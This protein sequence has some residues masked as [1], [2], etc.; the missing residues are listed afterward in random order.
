[1]KILSVQLDGEMVKSLE[2]K[3]L[4]AG[5][6]P[7]GILADV[8]SRYIHYSGWQHDLLEFSIEGADSGDFAS[9]AEIRSTFVRW[10]VDTADMPESL[11]W[12]GLALRALRKELEHVGKKAPE[13]AT[14]LAHAT[15][16]DSIKADLKAHAYP[17]LTEGCFEVQVAEGDYC[18]A[19]REKDGQ[20]Q[21]IGVVPTV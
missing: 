8:V 3:S 20:R 18:M 21:I 14:A 6:T 12:S 2:D 17:S 7:E 4:Q 5:K 9:Q 16:Q 13:L 15:W 11:A 19:F 10:G 1:M